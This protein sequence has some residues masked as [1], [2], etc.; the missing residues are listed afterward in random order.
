MILG[1][2]RSSQQPMCSLDYDEN[3]HLGDLS[4]SFTI[5]YPLVI[6][7]TLI[8]SETCVSYLKTDSYLKF[9]PD[10]EN[11]VGFAMPVTVF[12]QMSLHYFAIL[13]I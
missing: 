7:I 1:Q 13:S 10:S 4:Q 11:E 3:T 9:S 5:S 12:K 6:I 2:T 8:N